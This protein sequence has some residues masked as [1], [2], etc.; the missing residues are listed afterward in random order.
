M[1]GPGKQVMDEWENPKTVAISSGTISYLEAGSGQPLVFL[2]GI[3]SAARSWHHQIAAF[4][5]RRRVVAW[6]APGY[7]QS[8]PPKNTI[9]TAAD[10]AAALNELLGVLQI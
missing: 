7:A 6:N 10:Y 1:I 2:H 8:T 4:S 9:P 3:G 5:D